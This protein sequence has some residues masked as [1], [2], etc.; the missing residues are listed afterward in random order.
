MSDILH[1][2][3]KLKDFLIRGSVNNDDDYDSNIKSMFDTIV[4]NFA[5]AWLIRC[6]TKYDEPE[7]HRRFEES[8]IYDGK[9]YKG[10]D[11]I[12]D[13]KKHH[14]KTWYLF[15]K[16]APKIGDVL[17]FDDMK[18]LHKVTRVLELKGW[19]LLF[20]EIQCIHHIILMIR[21]IVYPS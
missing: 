10:F 1:D 8:Y 13:M 21:K 6:L 3:N 5:A 4:K 14:K 9:E 18:F 11:F 2:K 19:T 12:T 17:L 15:C 7:F 16:M 20:H